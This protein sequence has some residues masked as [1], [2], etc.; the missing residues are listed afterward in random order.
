M[1]TNLRNSRANSDSSSDNN[2]NNNNT[3][4]VPN[5]SL[6]PLNTL[7]LPFLPRWQLSTWQH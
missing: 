2:N 1:A 4:Q 7:L 5:L 6:P 3:L